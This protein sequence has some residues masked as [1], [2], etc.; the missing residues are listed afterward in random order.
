MTIQ[1]YVDWKG[2]PI[3]NKKQHG[4]AR[5]AFFVHT[6]MMVSNFIYITNMLNLPTYLHGIMHEDVASS[7]TTVTNLLGATCAF[8]LFGAF[9]SDSYI[10]RFKTILIFGPLGF[11]GF[12][13]LAVQAHLPSLHPPPCNIK[14][15]LANCEK[16]HGWNLALLYIGLYTVAVGDGCTRSCSP[17]LG[18]DQFDSDDPV[19]VLQKSSFF[20][21]ITFAI[22]FGGFT[23]LLLLVWIENN[24]GWDIGFGV[25]ALATLVGVLAIACGSPFFRNQMPTGSPLTRMLQV[26]VAA[27][28]KRNLLL[29]ESSEHLHQFSNKDTT[30][31]DLLPHTMGFKFLDKAAIADGGEIGPW[32]LC[33]ATQVEETKV[34]LKMIPIFFSSVFGSIPN[35]LLLTL[36]VQQGNTMNTK[37]GA[38]H[39]SPATLFIVPIAFQMVML[40]IYD[41]FIMPCLRRITG[42]VGGITHLQRIGFGFV[43][44]ALATCAAALVEKRRMRIVEE[45][46]LIQDSASAVPMSVLWLLPQFFFLGVVDVTSFVG[47]LEFFN[48]EA[49][50]GMKSIGTAIFWC[51]LGLASFFG[52]ITIELANK[53]SR[54]GADGRGWIEG[55]N[56][57]KGHLDRFY[58]LL[59]VMQLLALCN[60][61]YCAK[62][63][64]YRQNLHIREEKATSQAEEMTVI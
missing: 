31:M 46:G 16:A 41:R 36:T 17:A 34:V 8:S 61:V 54:D 47:L 6:Q 58:W 30:E 27:F 23:G 20:N 60:F 9:I 38:I 5:A 59:C 50:S 10:S 62:R 55:N 4:R 43:F 56:L 11:L 15:D 28:R 24:E 7:A 49:P 12:G 40:V 13:L 37:L 1:G 22:S 45:N 53:A 52:T 14:D 29:P 35:A 44:T 63:Y 18:G 39:I 2:K 25:C 3:I 57:N 64:V 33:T 42:Y 51:T 19:E 26:F 32:S 48:S 21:W